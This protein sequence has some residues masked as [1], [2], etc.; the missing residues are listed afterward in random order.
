ML[1]HMGVRFE[2]FTDMVMFIELDIRDGLNQCSNRYA[3]ANNKYMPSYD[4]S[5][6]LSYL[7]YYDVNNLYGWANQPLPYADFRWVND[8]HNFDHRVRLA[9]IFLRWTWSTRN[10]CMTRTLTYCS[11]RRARN[12]PANAMTS[13]LQHYKQ[14]R[15]R[16]VIHYCNNITSYIIVTCSSVLVTVSTKVHRI[17]QF[18]QFP[19][20]RDYIEL[21]TKFRTLTKI[22]KKIYT[23]LWITRYL[24]KS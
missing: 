5:K 3:R 15:Q 24:A 23:N 14:L 1:K 7:M 9:I 2:L 10:I 21:N 19:S 18:A 6:P 20:L 12:H 8:V 16:Y 22:K 17:L 11:V 13:S 4:P